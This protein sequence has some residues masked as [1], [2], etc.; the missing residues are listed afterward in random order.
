MA[1][2]KRKRHW[3]QLTESGTVIGIKI[4]LFIYWLFGRWGFRVFLYPVIT[5]YYWVQE[6]ARHA[7]R[8]YLEQLSAFSQHKQSKGLSGFKHFLMFGEVLLDKFLVW[9]DQIGLD[10]VVFETPTV[11]EA[12]DESKKGGVIIVSHLGNMEVCSALVQQFPDLEL[13]ILAFTQHAVKFNNM[14]KDASKN[15]RIESLQVTDM[16]PEVAMKL[17]DRINTGGYIIIAGDR[18]PVTGETRVSDVSFLGATASMPQGG[19]ILAALL[20][21]PV[22][23][24]FC[25]KQQDQYHIYLELFSQ[26]LAFPRKERQLALNTV[27]QQY[28]KRLEHYCVIAPLQ[29]FNFYSFWKKK[30]Q[31]NDE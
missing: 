29:W 2:E 11:F 30:E 17:S 21:C 9:T 25:L 20:K 27:V 19:F 8:E 5:Y 31:I 7:S 10:E 28:A 18:T 22:Y 12:M 1:R 14:M 6:T 24:L 16:T 15:K 26:Q 13:T 4:L 3:S 23:L